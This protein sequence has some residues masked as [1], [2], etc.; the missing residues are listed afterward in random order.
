MKDYE[1]PVIEIFEIK[2]EERLAGSD[3]NCAAETGKG[4]GCTPAGLPSNG[5]SWSP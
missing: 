3:C 4:N 1:K 5:N 2:P